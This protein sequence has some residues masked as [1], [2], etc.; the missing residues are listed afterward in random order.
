MNAQEYARPDLL[1][2]T[3]WLEGRLS[4]PN[5]RIVDCDEYGRY[6]RA[7]IKNALGI[8]VHHYIKHPDYSRDPTGHPLVA[9]PDT[10]AAFME[11]MGIGNDDLVVAYDKAGSLY[12]TRFWWVLNYYGH[13]N[14]KVLNGGWRKWFDEGRPATVEIPDV[15]K[16]H[17]TATINRDVVCTLDHGVASV[18]RSDTVFLDL[19]SDGEWDGTN[20]RGNRR[21]GHVPG[22][23]HLEW[24][25]FVT[26][27][28][29]R[30]FKPAH[31]LRA[32]LKER[33]VIP[34]KQI[35]TY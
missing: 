4:D 29:F 10:F 8:R 35:I 5:T 24:V 15:P 23:V 1:V 12:A 31:E 28:V 13:T 20:D 17:Y 7:H 14:V 33:G 11:S 19:R 16:R 26:D 22:A 9:D 6:S 2:E 3:D 27:D 18:D 25:N 21:A 30:T 34:E 32:M